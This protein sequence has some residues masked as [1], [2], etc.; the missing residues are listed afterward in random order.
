M[1]FVDFAIVRM[2]INDNMIGLISYECL[3]GQRRLF[4][5]KRPLS[6]ISFIPPV[7]EK[8]LIIAH[9]GASLPRFPSR[10]SLIIEE[11]YPIPVLD[12]KHSTMSKLQKA[13][14]SC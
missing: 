10:F 3:L 7:Y 5:I 6:L 12:K 11:I 4:A 8:A 14:P 9:F 13:F 1:H 2:L